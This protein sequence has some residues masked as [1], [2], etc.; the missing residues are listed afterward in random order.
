MP[1]PFAQYVVQDDPF[2]AF[3]APPPR[4]PST[5]QDFLQIP[6]AD[7]MGALKG[8]LDAGA[9]EV[10]NQDP[11]FMMGGPAGARILTKAAGIAKAGAGRILTSPIA[12]KVG[13]AVLEA[14]GSTPIIGPMGRGAVRGWK[15]A[16]KAAP[17]VAGA[18]DETVRMAAPAD[19]EATVRLMGPPAGVKPKLTVAQVAEKLRKEHGSAKAGRMLYGSARKGLKASDRQ[20]AIR[21][22]AP[23]ESKL[24]DAAAAAI[25]RELAASTAEEAFAYAQR[26]PNARAQEYFGKKLRDALFD[27]LAR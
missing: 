24:P 23:G 22:L 13:G 14:A 6:E 7:R 18:T 17:K 1:D 16:G 26:A 15:A 2:A 20:R 10:S 27:R 9:L 19:T 11:L 3:A 12:R 21:R 5:A 4:H 25:D 8:A